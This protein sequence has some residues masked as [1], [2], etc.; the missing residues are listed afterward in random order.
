MRRYVCIVVAGAAFITLTQT[1]VSAGGLFG[2]GGIFGGDVGE[3]FDRNVEEPITTPLVQG[4]TVGVTTAVGT[5]V[6]G[7]LGNPVYGAFVGEYV[8]ET[9]NERA[10]GKSPPIGRPAAHGTNGAPAMTASFVLAN[11]AKYIVNVKLFSRSRTV[12]WPSSNSSFSLKDG[13]PQTIKVH[14]N[15]G[16]KICYGAYYMNDDPDGI[17]WGKGEKGLHACEDCCLYCNNNSIAATF[18]DN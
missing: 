16:E 18:I 9:I 11:E 15:S 12:I 14:C 1:N 13:R 6:G 10:A 5:V 7:A 2:D 8:G 3:F 17:Y 4:T